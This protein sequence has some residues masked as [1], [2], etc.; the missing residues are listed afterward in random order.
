MSHRNTSVWFRTSDEAASRSSSIARST[1]ASTR[2]SHSR[3]NFDSDSSAADDSE[4][5]IMA[6]DM[7][8][9]KI[10][11]AYYTVA[12]ETLSFMED[13]M[14]PAAAAADCIDALK[15]QISPTTLL[16][17]SRLDE[18]EQ[19][20]TADGEMAE[21]GYRLLV[22]PSN[23]FAYETARSR[24]VALKI[25]EYKGP[26]VVA[27]QDLHDVSAEGGQSRGNLLKLAAWVDMDS[28]ITVGCAGAVLAY[29]QRMKAIQEGADRGGVL[30]IQSVEMFSL[31]NVMF[32]NADTL[33]SLQIFENEAHP[34]FHMQGK[35]G[36]GKEGLSLF[37][38][39]NMTR[40]PLG[41]RLLKQWFLR[42]SLSINVINERQES[43]AVLLR[44]D[45]DHVIGTLGKSLKRVKN[46][47]KILGQ[48]KRGKGGAQRGGEWSSVVDFV[49]NALKIRTVIQELAGGA[50]VPIVKKIL[51]TFE[52]PDLTDIGQIITDTIDFEE[53]ANVNRV[54]VKEA[55]DPRLDEMRR[56]Y[57]GMGDMLSEVARQITASA[58]L[59]GNV[60]NA[61][62][63]IYFPQIGYLVVVPSVTRTPSGLPTESTESEEVRPAFV[64][65]D[66]E[67]QFCTAT[68]WYYK[69]P[70]MRE[71]DDYFGDMYG[72]I[73]DREIEIIHEL[74]VRV[75][76]HETL[77]TD[78]VR[79]CSE[80]DCLMALAES[81]SKYKY[82]RPIMTEENVT[83]ITKGRHPLQ[84][85]C[86][87]AYVENDGFIVGGKDDG[88]TDED[89]SRRGSTETAHSDGPSMILLTGPNYS[90]K[91][92]YLKQTALIVYMA[93]VGCFVPAEHA[94]I[95][96]T[97]KILTRIQ[98][99]ESVSKIQS[100][101]MIDLQQISL[102]LRLATRRSLL[103]IDEFGKG[104]DSSD[105]AGLA[106]AV[107]EH[108]LTLPD[109][110][111]PKV[112]AATHYHE[113]FERGFL[114]EEKH[115]NLWCGHMRILLDSNAD[116][117][118]NQITYLYK[119]EAGRSHSSFGTVCAG[120][121]GIEQ[122]VVDRADEL[123]LL[124]ARGEDL[125]AACVQLTD[126]EKKELEVAESVARAFLG[127]FGEDVGVE[128]TRE[129]LARVL[130]GVEE[131]E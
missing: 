11:C 59:P 102:S 47:P 43:V 89:R 10:G 113:I 9:P 76:E 117:V 31:R 98:T 8:G 126:E 79:V 131:R 33:C 91:S 1:P 92:V 105:G 14:F 50:G 2:H 4:D 115:P 28:R 38:I 118:E 19:A 26:D 108:L 13:I 68:S 66:W 42:P 48:L 32:V 6:V 74:Q 39:I 65:E 63:V 21:R 69:N 62:N 84:E 128:N 7:K 52:V 87:P 130:S 49:L 78:C 5:V 29:L 127:E 40:S 20:T 37:G 123:I 101:F 35:G 57:A 3:Q 119:L 86:V 99:R 75:L 88:D 111:R 16:I 58:D 100:A 95:G 34:N 120:L 124:A 30:A 125:V 82:T 55:V 18:V 36:R 45:N 51:D 67:F 71:M 61:L 112:V 70:Q 122:A 97:D 60:V 116:S 80:L 85:L 15:F 24:L 12:T 17:P 25:G 23:E 53:S 103:I 94:T 106:C 83:R 81:A 129:Q 114:A 22:R 96:I 56:L 54:V 73:G 107:F 27:P 104:T 41:H 121:N 46:I 109:S 44:A 72:L 64:G 110:D 90:G 93:H 77:L